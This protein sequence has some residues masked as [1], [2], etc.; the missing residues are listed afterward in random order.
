MGSFMQLKL[1]VTHSANDIRKHPPTLCHQFKSEQETQLAFNWQ[2][3]IL[4]LL[5]SMMW[6]TRHHQTICDS[7]LS[8]TFDGVVLIYFMEMWHLF[9]LYG[10]FCFFSFFPSLRWGIKSIEYFLKRIRT[11]ILMFYSTLCTLH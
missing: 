9:R 7:C 3:K 5:R 2:P 1:W 6:L 8:G 10:H 4:F 11:W